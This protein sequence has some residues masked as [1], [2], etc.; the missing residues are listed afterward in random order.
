M[1][2]VNNTDTRT[3]ILS[4]VLT[5]SIF[6]TFVSIVD[7]ELE[8]LLGPSEIVYEQWIHT[9][10]TVSL[11]SFNRWLLCWLTLNKQSCPYPSRENKKIVKFEIIGLNVM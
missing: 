1:S 8:C 6:L 9:L 10:Q 2:K 7:F 3:F 5:L 11:L 4:L